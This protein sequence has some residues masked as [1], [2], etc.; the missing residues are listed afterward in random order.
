MTVT[1]AYLAVECARPG[2]GHRR[3]EHAWGGCVVRQM[4]GGRYPCDCAGFVDPSTPMTAGEWVQALSAGIAAEVDRL[5]PEETNPAYRAQCLAE[6]AG[7]VS[8]A[9]TK[10]RHASWA[11]DS[12]C[13][14]KTVQEWTE[15][16]RVELAQLVGVA[17]DIAHR[18][19]F[20]L[21]ADVEQVLAVLQ[22]REPGT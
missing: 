21:A 8:R 11:A 14:G 19:G 10:R 20:D 13:K 1:T 15:E 22:E 3:F 17:F 5:W 7:E 4:Y 16:L 6:E 2:C 12:R 9:I 18:E